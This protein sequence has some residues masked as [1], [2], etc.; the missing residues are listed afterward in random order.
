ME[1]AHPSQTLRLRP[2]GDSKLAVYTDSRSG[3]LHTQGDAVFPG[4]VVM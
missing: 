4:V 3:F 2:Q 1:P